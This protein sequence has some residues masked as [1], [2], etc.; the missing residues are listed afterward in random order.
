MKK[1]LKCSHEQED[2]RFCGKCGAEIELSV[3]DE[4]AATANTNFKQIPQQPQV[5]QESSEQIE[6]IKEQSKMYFNYYMQQLKVP[7][8][9]FNATELSLKNSAI[10]IV[11]YV[12]L[13]ALSVYVL[14]KGLFGGGFYDYYGPSF[15]KIFLYMSV[16][17]ILLITISLVAVFVTTKLFSED[18]TFKEVISKFGGYYML[19]IMLSILGILLA[20]FKSYSFASI[21]I[22]IG[23]AIVIGVIPI[24]I[25]VKL[26]SSKSKGI[27]SFYAFIFYIIVTIVLMVIVASFII[28]STIGEY[29]EYLQ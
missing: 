7:S 14:I 17:F 21:S 18:I 28:D 1:C 12:I 23:L 11:L 19:P 5:T 4:V 20:L 25:M 16:F 13:T 9:H 29:L 10:S 27:D 26:L 22:Y 3:Q 8:T 6:K 24:Y 15:F 2:G